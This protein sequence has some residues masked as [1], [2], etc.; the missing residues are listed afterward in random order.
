MKTAAGSGSDIGTG[1]VSLLG[2]SSNRWRSSNTFGA[3]LPRTMMSSKPSAPNYGRPAPPGPRSAK[4]YAT[5]GSC[6]ILH[7]TTFYKAVVQAILLY[8]SETWVLSR[9]A[10]ARLEGFHIRAA[11]RM[12]K[13]H[14]P[15]QGPGRTWIYPRLVDALQECGLK[16]MEKYIGIRQQT[17]VV[18]MATRP[19]LTECRQGK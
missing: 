14:K 11:Y 8:G 9:M 4:F 17:I 2:R 18:Y 16:I 6:R 1:I 5:M 10:L 12:A 13:I 3:F 7:N 19:I 15:K